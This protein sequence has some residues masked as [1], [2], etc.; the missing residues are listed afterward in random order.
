M[1]SGR[2]GTALAKLG[3]G[4]DVLMLIFGLLCT[5]F[6]P[7]PSYMLRVLRLCQNSD[8]PGIGDHNFTENTVT[9]IAE[10][11]RKR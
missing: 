6:Q 1:G 9:F 3:S 2:V 5:T 7:C 11:D 8:A 4:S 10:S